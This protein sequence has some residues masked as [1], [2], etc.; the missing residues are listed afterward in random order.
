MHFR[1]QLAVLRFLADLAV[2]L[3]LAIVANRAIDALIGQDMQNA[4]VIFDHAFAYD[5]KRLRGGL[6][7]TGRNRQRSR[8]LDLAADMIGGVSAKMLDQTDRFHR[9][10]ES[11]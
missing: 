5:F 10:S 9:L 3:E 11:R 2:K 8:D 1:A 7:R 4:L 6:L